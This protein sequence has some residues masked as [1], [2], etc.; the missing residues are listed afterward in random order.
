MANS[1]STPSCNCPGAAP[2]P[3]RAGA[4][5]QASRTA[6]TLPA[7][8]ISLG[9][10][11]FP[12][13]PFCWA[14]YMSVLGS[15]G[16]AKLPYLPWMLPVLLALLAVHLLLLLRQLAR[17]RYWPFVCSA[18]GAACVLLGRSGSGQQSGL[19]LLGIGLLI[20]GSLLNNFSSTLSKAST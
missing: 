10:A 18:L 3:A 20:A 8:L 13:C 7:A 19:L 14:A 4:A 16:I 11:F 5:V 15:I 2:A 9:I 17:K 6:K 1:L 12:K